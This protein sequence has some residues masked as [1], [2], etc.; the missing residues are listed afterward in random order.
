MRMPGKTLEIHQI[1]HNT[2]GEWYRESRT[3]ADQMKH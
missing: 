2:N 1:E 3:L